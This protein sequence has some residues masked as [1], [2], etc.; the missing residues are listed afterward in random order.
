M[1]HPETSPVETFRVVEAKEKVEDLMEIVEEH[2]DTAEDPIITKVRE[3][4]KM[5]MTEITRNG[6]IGNQL[7]QA[8][9]RGHR[10][11]LVTI[12]VTVTLMK[13]QREENPQGTIPENLRIRKRKEQEVL[14]KR[15]TVE[16]IEA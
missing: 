16:E 5:I 14:V 10:T 8:E 12:A 15:D 7:E 11:N 2:Q 1:H 9:A 6:M 3:K 4:E 13:N